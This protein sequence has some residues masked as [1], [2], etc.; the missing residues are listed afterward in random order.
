MLF[1]SLLLA[2]K[3][4]SDVKDEV[5]RANQPAVIK[6][7][8]EIAV[9]ITG[10]AWSGVVVTDEGE[11]AVS[12]EGG[13]MDQLALSA[14]ARD[15]LRL[16]VRMAFAEHHAEKTGVALPLILDDPTSSVDAFRAPR[17]FDVLA[18]FSHRHQVILMTHDSA[19]VA[20]AIAV[21]ATEVKLSVPV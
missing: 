19:T 17:L 11:I 9:A 3:L 1:R 5:E 21:G 14:G 6:R 15:V 4:V 12:Q 20:L 10:G 2:E 18:D 8:S 7:V 16:C 13:W